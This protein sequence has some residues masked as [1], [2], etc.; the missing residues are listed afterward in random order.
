MVERRLNEEDPHFLD[1]EDRFP[2]SRVILENEI[3]YLPE[4]LNLLVEGCD[5]LVVLPD[6]LPQLIPQLSL[7]L[8]VSVIVEVLGAMDEQLVGE[9][10]LVI[11]F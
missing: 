4:G 9:S 6:F 3:E 5:D 2:D 1:S 8:V 10:V 7:D 11:A